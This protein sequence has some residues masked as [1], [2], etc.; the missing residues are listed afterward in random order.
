VF[1]PESRDNA[2]LPVRAIS[3]MPY[4]C[5]MPWM[6]VIFCSLPC[7][8]NMHG[9]N[10]AAQNDGLKCLHMAASRLQL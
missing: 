4:G 5:R 1:T 6:A 7:V 2:T 9:I 10:L 8:A 3:R